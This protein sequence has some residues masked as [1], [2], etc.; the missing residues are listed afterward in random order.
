MA[1]VVDDVWPT[2]TGTNSEKKPP[3]IGL[4]GAA[5]DDCVTV[6]FWRLLDWLDWL[7]WRIVEVLPLG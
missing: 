3:D 6:W 4:Q 2:G 5:K 7:E 1:K